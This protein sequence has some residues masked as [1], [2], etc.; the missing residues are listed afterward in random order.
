MGPS[1]WFY[2]LNG[3]RLSSFIINPPLKSSSWI[4]HE[5]LLKRHQTESYGRL[6]RRATSGWPSLLPPFGITPFLEQSFNYD[7][8]REGVWSH[9]H[10]GN[11][12]TSREPLT[13]A[14]DEWHA[15]TTARRGAERRPGPSLIASCQAASVPCKQRRS[16]RWLLLT[17]TA[18]DPNLQSD[19]ERRRAGV[20]GG[21]RWG[22][23]T[24]RSSFWQK[25]RSRHDYVEKSSSLDPSSFRSMAGEQEGRKARK[26]ISNQPP[27]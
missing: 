4:L 26:S 18:G 6:L 24:N 16:R 20:R 2:R 17:P 3:H 25:K 27:N 15:R 13:N 1:G 8:W 23:S 12:I 21:N 5:D 7:P 11:A 14:M 9:C 19:V 10:Y 22:S